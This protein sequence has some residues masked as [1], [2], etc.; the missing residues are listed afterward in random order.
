MGIEPV[1]FQFLPAQ[2][3]IARGEVEDRR[4]FPAPQYCP[5]DS[6]PLGT[7]SRRELRPGGE[8]ARACPEPVEGVR[9]NKILPSPG[10]RG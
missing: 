6:S 10:G 4:G 1:Q 3:K 9:G 5:H 7:P 8:R 2:P